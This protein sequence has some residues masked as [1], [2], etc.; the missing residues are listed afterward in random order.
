[1]QTK[2]TRR[3]ILIV[4]STLLV[5]GIAGF[6]AFQYA[7]QA[8]KEQ[9]ENALGPNGEVKEIRVGLTGIEITGIRIRAPQ[10]TGNHWPTEDELRAEHILIT[11]SIVD[12]MTARISLDTIHVEG[13]YISMLRAA[14]GQMKILPSLLERKASPPPSGASAKEDK[15]GEKQATPISIGKVILAN[16]TIEFFDATLRA[17][18]VKLRLEQI[19]AGIGKLH[20][21]ELTG[22]TSIK[23]DGVLKGVRQDGHFSLDGSIELASKESGL[24]TKLRGVDMVV[25]QPYL[26]KATE[27]GVK[28]GTLDLDLKTSVS[29]GKLRAPGTLTLSDLELTSATDTFMGLP[30]NAAIAMMKNKKGKISVRFVL[31]GDI[32]DP[33]FSLNEDLTTRIGTSMAS[34]LGVSIEGLTKELGN[35]GAGAAK[36]LG[37]SFGKLNRK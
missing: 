10:G 12:L 4:G 2:T 17:T 27:T 30:R 34:M 26:I 13:A 9:V 31:E 14:N 1:M 7:I 16:G 28:Q 23:A 5:L 32:N 6:C 3:R 37:E 22:Q 24:S 29:K 11:P 18:P 21:P 20:L 35:V 36:A 25:L 8:L 19:N 15:S 33:R